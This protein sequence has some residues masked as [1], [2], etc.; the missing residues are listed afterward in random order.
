MNSWPKRALQS[1]ISFFSS[2][3][4]W[5]LSTFALRLLVRQHACS[6][7]ISVLITITVAF[8]FSCF[9]FLFMASGCEKDIQGSDETVPYT[10]ILVGFQSRLSFFWITF[11][12]LA[13]FVS[14]L[15]Q[16]IVCIGEV[17]KYPMSLLSILCWVE[18]S[19][20]VGIYI[21]GSRQKS[22]TGS[23]HQPSIFNTPT[24]SF[25]FTDLKQH[26]TMADTHPAHLPPSELGTK[27]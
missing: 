24:H 4:S 15:F 9:I 22:R 8:S 11:P 3:H 12:S 27:D 7:S 2:L 14:W 5:D 6:S 1:L 19:R 21:C 13:S 17:N 20:V 18:Y 26:K 23:K 16:T 10:V 25:Y